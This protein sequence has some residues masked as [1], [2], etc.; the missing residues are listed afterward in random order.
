VAAISGGKVQPHFVPYPDVDLSKPVALSLS[1]VPLLEVLRYCGD[2][3]D[4]EFR[5]EK[6]AV[7]V[8]RKMPPSKGNSPVPFA[9]IK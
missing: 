7:S 6:Y 2:L 1:D 9:I 3:T 5:P 4:T 8:R